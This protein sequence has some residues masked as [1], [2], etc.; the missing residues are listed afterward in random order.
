[1][2]ALSDSWQQQI[3]DHRLVVIG[4][5]G[6]IIFLLAG[7]LLTVQGF[8]DSNA[9]LRRAKEAAEAATQAKTEFW[10]T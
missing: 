2:Q 8:Q 3:T 10:P 4:L 6:M 5:T 9:E 1:M 7:S